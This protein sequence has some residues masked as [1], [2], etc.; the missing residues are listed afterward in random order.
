MADISISADNDKVTLQVS[1]YG[2]GIPTAVL[3]QGSQDWMGSFGVGLRGMSERLR[4]LGGLLDIS[5]SDRGTNVRA[6][7]PLT[8]PHSTTA[9]A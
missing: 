7:V 6:S 2:K 5:S 3:E 4:Q 9:S 8:K 1:D